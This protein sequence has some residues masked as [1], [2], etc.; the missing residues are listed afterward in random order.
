MAANAY[1]DA[2]ALTSCWPSL[3]ITIGVVEVINDSQKS[4]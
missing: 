3:A 4:Y 2:G 1:P